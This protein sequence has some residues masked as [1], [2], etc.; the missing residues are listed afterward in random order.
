MSVN[1]K[2]NK[3]AYF[4]GSGESVVLDRLVKVGFIEKVTFEQRHERR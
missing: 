1:N 4:I 2:L 3:K